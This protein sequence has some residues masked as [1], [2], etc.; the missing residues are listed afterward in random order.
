[1]KKN[2]IKDE[3]IKLDSIGAV[4]FTQSKMIYTLINDK[5]CF[6]LGFKLCDM[7]DN[8]YCALSDEDKQNIRTI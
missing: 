8:T 4:L 7:T 1:M 3:P 2:I 5:P 6:S